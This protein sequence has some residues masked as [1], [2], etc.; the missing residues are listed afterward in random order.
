MKK[1]ITFIVLLLGII[2]LLFLF[3]IIWKSPAYYKPEKQHRIGAPIIDMETYMNDESDHRR[4]Y[5][6]TINAKTGGKVIVVGTEHLNDPEHKQFDSIRNYWASNNPTI[7]LVEGR[8]GF[9]CKWLH[10]PI[11]KFGEG[12]L[13]A[14]LAKENNVD[15]YTWEP[16]R[17]DEIEL[18]KTKYSAKKLAMFYSLRP[19]F[20]ISKEERQNKPE[21]ILQKLIDE[22]TDYD[23]LKGAI[24]SWEEID[25]IWK[26][27]FPDIDWKNFST[28]YGWPGYFHDIW[29][30]SNLTRDEHMIQIILE[31]IDKGETVFVTMGAS[32]APRIE[33]ALR[34]T[35]L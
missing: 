3:D 13:T 11:E 8:L 28:G 21:D 32:H 5:I 23:Y 18:L 30:S 2:L 27:D 22:R 33:D 29:N 26:Q 17:E 24:T 15:L 10:N 4:P 6:Y 14:K 19:F 16:T 31:C 1:A 12:G 7:A 34:K 35:I 20:G 9:Y 25:S